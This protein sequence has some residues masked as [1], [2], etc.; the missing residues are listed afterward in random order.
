MGELG[1]ERPL[2]AAPARAAGLGRRAPAPRRG[3]ARTRC[4]SPAPG[5]PSRRCAR[6]TACCSTCPRC[7]GS[8]ATDA[9]AGTA[10]VLAGTRIAELGEPLRAAG[11]RA[12]EPGRRR[13]AGDRRRGWR[14]ARTAPAASAASRRWCDRREVVLPSGDLVAQDG[15]AAGLALGMLGVLGVAR[16]RGRPGLPAAR[17]D[18]AL[19]LRRGRASSGRSPRRRARATSSSSGCRCSTGASS[20]R[21]PTTDDEPWGDPP[22]P[23]H[24]SRR[25]RSSAT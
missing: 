1:R 14:R 2:H 4:A 22:P 10:T 8:L 5:T 21:S 24:R 23:P 9:E 3:D 16:A 17:A 11:A 7:P 12:R 25:A 19:R 20:S 6:P 18:V 13:H 15:A